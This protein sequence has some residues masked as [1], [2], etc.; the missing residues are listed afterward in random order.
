MDVPDFDVETLR[1]EHES[2]AEWTLRR[3]FL[4]THR[5]K[6]PLKRLICLASCF[7]NLECY[8]CTYPSGVMQELQAL[9]PDIQAE[10]D[11]HR[12]VIKEVFE[13]SKIKFVKASEDDQ[14]AGGGRS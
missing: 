12:A 8:G 6:Y 11:H 10:I 5:D 13:A 7:I 14:G 4:D 9:C 2:G 1:H 3:A